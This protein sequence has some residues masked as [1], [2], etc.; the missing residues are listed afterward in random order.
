MKSIIIYYSL[1]GNTKFIADSLNENLNGDVLRL[2]PIEDINR[3]GFKRFLQ[4]GK[5]VIFKYKPDLKKFNKDLSQ[6]DLIIFGSPI[7]ANHYVPA[8]NTF[9]NENKIVNKKVA[10]YCCHGGGST[11]NTFESFQRALNNNE[12]L[13]KIDFKD[14]LKNNKDQC[15]KEAKE[16]INGILCKEA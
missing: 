8:F 5:Q 1:E 3:T 13:G 10:F 16:W 4:G 11:K 2:E 14:P 6:Y 9:F 7:W 12:V 15:K